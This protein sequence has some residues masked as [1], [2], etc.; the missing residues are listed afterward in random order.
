VNW[1]CRP[2]VR[3]E[4]LIVDMAMV[5]KKKERGKNF[6]QVALC[7]ELSQHWHIKN[8]PINPCTP[9]Q[10]LVMLRCMSS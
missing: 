6:E 3:Q 9:P 4:V 2:S 1:P 5:V 8:K 7:D 10:S